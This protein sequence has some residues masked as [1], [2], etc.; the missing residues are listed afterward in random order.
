MQFSRLLPTGKT[1]LFSVNPS[2]VSAVQQKVGE[3]GDVVPDHTL[4][5]VDNVG[6]VTVQDQ[7]AQ[8][9]RR[10]GWTD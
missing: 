3:N 8:V 9:T 1:V 5:W 2:A 6:D 10:L 7:Y 4:L